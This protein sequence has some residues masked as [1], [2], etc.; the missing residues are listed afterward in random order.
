MATPEIKSV[1]KAFALLECLA[2]DDTCVS[3]PS[4]AKRCGLSVATAHR[5]LA[6]LES[7][8]AVIH[9]GP[10]EYA[11]GLRLLELARR[12][13]FEALLASATTPILNRITRATGSTV[14]VGVLDPERMVTYVARSATRATRIPT[15]PGVKLEAYCSGLGKVLLADLPACERDTYL[16]EGPFPA[17]TS[18]TICEPEALGRELATVR[19]RRFAVDDC[20]MFDNLRCVAVPILGPDGKVVAALSASQNSADLPGAKVGALAA[21]L[22]GHAAAI[23]AKLFPRGGAHR[24]A[25]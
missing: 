21:E 8:G 20:E 24:A 10:G 12:S 22:A 1:G 16:S 5:L 6:T 15:M 19:S 17:L 14:H 13:S 9:T 23:S 11:I 4:M 18:R 7:L 2:A 3:L 25:H